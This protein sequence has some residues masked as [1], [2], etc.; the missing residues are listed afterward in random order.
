MYP[1]FGEEVG[2]EGRN[3]ENPIEYQHFGINVLLLLIV[4]KLN[5]VSWEEVGCINQ[6]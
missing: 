6:H 2:G 3:N 1:L 5:N 4:R